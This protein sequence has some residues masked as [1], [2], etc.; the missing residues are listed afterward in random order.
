MRY[1]FGVTFHSR[2]VLDN[3]YPP[4]IA[5]SRDGT[6][7]NG[8]SAFH[9]GCTTVHIILLY[10]PRASPH[11]RPGFSI[12]IF[13]RDDTLRHYHLDSKYLYWHRWPDGDSVVD[14]FAGVLVFRFKR[15][16]KRLAKASDW[17][18]TFVVYWPRTLCSKAN[19]K[20]HPSLTGL[21]L[22]LMFAPPFE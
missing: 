17:T 16:L 6:S 22:W 19:S 18:S 13:E 2:W 3:S 5:R 20:Y 15:F 1:V 7:T 14:D 9:R 8:G 10:S 12:H 4:P 21:S 11:L